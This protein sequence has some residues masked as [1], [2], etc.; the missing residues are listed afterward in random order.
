MTDSDEKATRSAASFSGMNDYA[1]SIRS[2][3]YG[4]WSGKLDL[5]GFFD[6][7]SSAIERTIKF[8]AFPI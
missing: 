6:A 8:G 3:V 4:L 2:A 7:A 1:R 5:Q